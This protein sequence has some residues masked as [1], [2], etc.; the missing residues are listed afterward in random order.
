LI[1]P[2]DVDRTIRLALQR[3]KT[4]AST[5]VG[6]VQASYGASGNSDEARRELIR[7]LQRFTA[8]RDRLE[9]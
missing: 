1:P 8:W 6:A 4:R 5:A 9:Q 7:V 3:V 2:D